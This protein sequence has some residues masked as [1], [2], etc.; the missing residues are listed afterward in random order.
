MIGIKTQMPASCEECNFKGAKWCYIEIWNNK[1][2]R[3]VPEEGRPNWCPL[4]EIKE[5][6]VDKCCETCKHKGCPAW[7]EPCDGCYLASNLEDYW[8]EDNG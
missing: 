8:E 6:T 4:T 1:G 2:A 7:E 3:E 5:Q